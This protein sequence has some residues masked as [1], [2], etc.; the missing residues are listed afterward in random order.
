MD[1]RRELMQ[2]PGVI[3]T[4]KQGYAG[5]VDSVKCSASSE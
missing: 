2:H 3:V 1:G 4:L 5:V